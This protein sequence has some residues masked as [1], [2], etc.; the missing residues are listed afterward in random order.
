MRKAAVRRIATILMLTQLE[1]ITKMRLAV[2]KTAVYGKYLGRGA[3]RVP[4]P[5]RVHSDGPKS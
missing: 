3:N 2:S 1:S 5:D 4:C